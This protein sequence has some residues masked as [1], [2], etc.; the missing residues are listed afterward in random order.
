MRIIH[1][2]RSVLEDESICA[3]SPLTEIK[4]EKKVQAAFRKALKPLSTNMLPTQSTFEALMKV[5]LPSA[6]T[7]SESQQDGS[8]LYCMLRSDPPTV[9][10]LVTVSS[11]LHGHAHILDKVVPRSIRHSLLKFLVRARCYRSSKQYSQQ[12]FVLVIHKN[13]LF[14]YLSKS[15]VRS[16]YNSD[17]IYRL[18]RGNHCGEYKYHRRS[19]SEMICSPHT[20]SFQ[21]CPHCSKYRFQL[22]VERNRRVTEE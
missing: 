15:C 5:D 11:D 16:G 1:S 22:F 9:I 4:D 14:N 8:L 2:L 6:W 17:Y 7:L 10:R 18:Q 20:S 21:R 3:T 12:S 19:D 13:I